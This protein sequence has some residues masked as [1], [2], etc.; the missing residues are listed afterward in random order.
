[1]VNVEVERVGVLGY[2]IGWV[3]K[4]SSLFQVK[5]ALC[6]DELISNT[7]LSSIDNSNNCRSY[8]DEVR[9]DISSKGPMYRNLLRIAN[10]YETYGVGM[11]LENKSEKQRKLRKLLVKDGA[12]L[13]CLKELRD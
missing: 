12:N 3:G 9:E 4:I 2:K 7:L 6:D 10:K 13:K 5:V 1:L 11:I 8:Y